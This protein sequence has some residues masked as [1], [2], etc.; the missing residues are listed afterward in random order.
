M[1]GKEKKQRE[2]TENL[3][4]VFREVQSKHQLAPGDFPNLVES[5]ECSFLC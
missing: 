4:A 5:F 1:I 2:L 3:G